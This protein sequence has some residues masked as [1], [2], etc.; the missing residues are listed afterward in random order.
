MHSI[1][2]KVIGLFFIIATLL[3]FSLTLILLILEVSGLSEKIVSSSKLKNNLYAGRLLAT[4]D[5]YGQVLEEDPY[6]KFTIQHLH[7]YY[8]FSL[9]WKNADIQ[10]SNN[11]VV[12]I[13]NDGF[14][15][16]P[17]EKFNSKGVLLG[18][19]TA[20]GHFSSNDSETLAYHI[21]KKL[22]TEIINRNAPSWNSHQELIALLKMPPTYKLSISLS[23]LNDISISCANIEGNIADRVIDQPESFDVLAGYFNDIRGG[24]KTKSKETSMVRKVKNKLLQF[25]PDTYLLLNLI[26]SEYFDEGVKILTNKKIAY[27]NNYSAQSIAA[28][29]IKNQDAMSRISK[30]IG[31][32]HY[33]ILQ[34]Q[35][36]I[37]NKEYQSFNDQDGFNNRRSNYASEVYSIVMQSEY[38]KSNPC[39][40][41]TKADLNSQS[42]QILFTGENL[43]TSA[44]FGDNAHLLDNGVHFY[45]N[46]ISNFIS[47]QS[48]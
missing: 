31:A 45:S 9:P 18:G 12:N 10:N 35:I 44:L 7:P 19:S 17:S 42:E 3:F 34:P 5:Y 30:S 33:L 47:E 14:R 25:F 38:C 41:L 29:F 32:I 43:N 36:E 26:R 27:C 22:N 11:N 2:V 20:F 8:L 24:V 21:S 40:D 1:K 28:S 46:L 15:N 39:L 16:N 4:T 23:L 13:N 37:S 6:S 48:I